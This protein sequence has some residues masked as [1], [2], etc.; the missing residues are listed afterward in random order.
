MVLGLTLEFLR[1]ISPDQE[2][3]MACLSESEFIYFYMNQFT[4]NIFSAPC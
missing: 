2:Y 1:Y 4:L 3:R